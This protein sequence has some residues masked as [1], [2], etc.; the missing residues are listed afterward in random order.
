MSILVVGASGATGRLLVEQLLNEGEAVKAIVR[1]TRSLPL[2][3]IQHNNL[4][5]TEASLL[6]MT[7]A[8]LQEQVH[9]CYA[10]ASCLGHNLTLKGIFGHPKKLV[11]HSVKRLCQAAENT[12]PA[13]PVKFVLMNTTGNQNQLAGEKIKL[14]HRIVVSLLRYLLPP[15]A[16][17]EHAAAYLQTHHSTRDNSIE[18]VTVR[19][20]SLTNE[21][22]LSAYDV[23][24]SPTR[25]PIFDSGKTSR[26]NVAGFMKQLIVDDDTWVKWRGKMPV[27]YNTDQKPTI[28]FR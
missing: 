7:D 18:W 6:E 2:H 24:P 21:D 5:I 16:D 17:N 27:I 9:G 11:T 12:N 19:P 1:S 22:E 23:F 20:D 25:D 26:I 28:P 13:L 10:I 8:E 4:T 3:L 15:H 14:G